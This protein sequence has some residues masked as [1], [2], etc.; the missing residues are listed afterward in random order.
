MKANGSLDARRWRQWPCERDDVELPFHA[1]ENNVMAPKVSIIPNSIVGGSSP[2]TV[3]S[4]PASTPTFI[5]GNAIAGP[6]NATVGTATNKPMPPP[7]APKSGDG[8]IANT[9][10]TPS[11]E[12]YKQGGPA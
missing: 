7:L 4:G 12:S 5:H 3:Q 6:T 2:A 10:P 9:Q 11:I 8:S 1:E